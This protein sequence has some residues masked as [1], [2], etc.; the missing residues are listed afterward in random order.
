MY[1]TRVAKIEPAISTELVALLPKN[2]KGFITSVFRGDE[3]NEFCGEKQC[4]WKE[5]LNKSS[6]ETIEIK[7]NQPLGF[8]VIKPENLI[9]KYETENKKKR[10]IQKKKSL[11]ETNKLKTKETTRWFS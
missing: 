8:L 7:K 6:E 11:S 5:L 4:L 2:S 10:T 3:F 1:L 9:F